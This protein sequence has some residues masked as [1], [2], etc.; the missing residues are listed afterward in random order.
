MKDATETGDVV[1]WGALPGNTTKGQ[2]RMFYGTI[3]LVCCKS[4]PGTH[5]DPLINT[6]AL[7]WW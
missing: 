6:A 2:G 7:M 4:C 5:S 3:V 1:K